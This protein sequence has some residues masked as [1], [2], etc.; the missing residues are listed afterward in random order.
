MP[1]PAGSA[2]AYSKQGVL[3]FPRE[4]IPADNA[5]KQKR[6]HRVHHY[7]H[8]PSVST[9]KPTRLQPDA[10]GRLP[11]NHDLLAVCRRRRRARILQAPPERDP[12]PKPAGAAAYA[13]AAPPVRA[14]GAR[15]APVPAVRQEEVHSVAVSRAACG[16]GPG[17]SS[18]AHVFAS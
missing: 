13:P 14:A 5:Q 9:E 12:G 18:C 17:Q 3:F 10:P 15:A 2:A 1:T 6:S 4:V 16:T 8:R 7:K 11:P